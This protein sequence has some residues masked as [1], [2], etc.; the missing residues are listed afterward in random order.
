MSTTRMNIGMTRGL[1]VLERVLLSSL[2]GVAPMIT[3]ADSG[4]YD[5]WGFQVV[6]P[7]GVEIS[8]SSPAGDFDL[9]RVARSGTTRQ[10]LLTIYAGHHPETGKAVASTA[11]AEQILVGGISADS[12]TSETPDG[13]LARELLVKLPEYPLEGPPWPGY[14]HIWYRGLNATDAK[15]ADQIIDTIKPVPPLPEKGMKGP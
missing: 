9:Y 15:L 1:R 13:M 3:F 8:K 11:R 4:A 10:R 7:K 14:L 2:V 6:L 5:G 12:R